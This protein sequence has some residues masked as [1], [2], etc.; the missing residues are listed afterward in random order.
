MREDQRL[1]QLIILICVGV[2]G[3]CCVGQ[4]EIAL[5]SFL[6]IK[7]SETADIF[8]ISLEMRSSTS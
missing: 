4:G 3:L 6:E 5:T 2:T 7:Y 8:L 1:F